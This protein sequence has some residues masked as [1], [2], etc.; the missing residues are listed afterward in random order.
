MTMTDAKGDANTDPKADSKTDTRVPETLVDLLRTLER[1]RDLRPFAREC[2]LTVRELR[3]RLSVWRRDLNTEVDAVA[4]GVAA[5]APPAPAPRS[6]RR[7]FPEIP[8]AATL[9]RSPL[10]AKGSP[11]IEIFTDGASRGNPGPAAVGIVFRQMDG[12]E[13]CGHGEAI[14]ATTNNVAEYRAVLVALQFCQRWSVTRVHLFLDS[15]LVARQLTGA[16]RVKSPD[17]LPLYQ[18][19]QHLAKQLREFQIRHVP[20]ERNAH[21]DFLANVALDAQ[22]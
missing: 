9:K 1:S 14:G 18:Q 12:P 7:A 17:L 3:R 21:A 8:A 6:K 19:V 13:L 15:E 11:V 22:R 4:N 10:P 2:G 16:Y 5:A 20:R